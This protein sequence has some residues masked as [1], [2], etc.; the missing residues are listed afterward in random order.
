[1]QGLTGQHIEDRGRFGGGTAAGTQDVA[2]GTQPGE[3]ECNSDAFPTQSTS[4]VSGS[5]RWGAA[6]PVRC[7]QDTDFKYS[8]MTIV[9]ES[10]KT[11][12]QV[13]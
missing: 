8:F 1:M 2:E 11:R 10:H 12:N 4:P 13:S 7:V 3:A 5:T 6:D 9:P